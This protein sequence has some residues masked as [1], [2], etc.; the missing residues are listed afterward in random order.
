MT[1][2]TSCTT[3][4]ATLDTT[5]LNDYSLF[6]SAS[7]DSQEAAVG[8]EL[9][10]EP[11]NLSEKDLDVLNQL[12]GALLQFSKSLDLLYRQSV[13][14]IQ[15]LWI[16]RWLDI[17]KPESL[18]K[19]SQMKRF[20]TQVPIVIRPD[21]L[22]TENGFS[23]TEIDS[24]PGGIGFTAGMNDLYKKSGFDVLES[25]NSMGHAFVDAIKAQVSDIENPVI[26]VVVSDEAG[27]YLPEWQ[28]LQ[29]HLDNQRFLVVHPKQLTLVRD[30]LVAVLEDG[31]EV[32][33]DLI[34]R[35]FELFDLPNI[36]NVD[37]I[38]YAIKKQWVACTPPFKPHLEEKMGFALFHHPV[39]KPFWK[40]ELK[41]YYDF[42]L[43]MIPKTWVMDSAVLPPSAVISDLT[44]DGE[45]V[46]SYLALKDL[47]Q[48]GRQ[49]VIKPSGFSELAWGSRGVTIGHDL[50][51]EEWND[52]VEAALNSFD[53]T[54]YILQE[55]RHPKRHTIKRL[56]LNTNEPRDFSARTRL[57]PYYFIN[58]DSVELAGVLAT[59]CPDDKKII[60]GMK[61]AI[62]SPTRV[63]SKVD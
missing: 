49:W 12:G 8:W 16:A 31:E 37:L 21:L 25:E 39:L 51:Q 2:G 24:V 3:V 26:A 6:H 23:L 43:P 15:P 55:Y 58:G 44:I 57:C 28:W 29:K 17:G 18:L 41:E 62:L 53:Q 10:P 14:G 20:K 7:V 22:M 35:F 19:Y 40:K 61:D 47:S 59:S 38:Q 13:K 60:H 5:L 50:P 33:I 1:S 48:K 27:D 45:P 56:D 52:R 34:Y 11:F 4:N 63:C 32:A 36:P 9:S 54:P 42:L 46:Q 30:R